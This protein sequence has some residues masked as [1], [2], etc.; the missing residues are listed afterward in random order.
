MRFID[1]IR[2]SLANLSRSKSRTILTM[3]GMVIGTI[4]VVIMISLG[5]GMRVATYETYAAAGSQL[6]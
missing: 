6:G 1:I 2:M 3:S 5:I 4:S